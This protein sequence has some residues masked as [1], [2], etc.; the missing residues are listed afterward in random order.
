MTK[1]FWFA[2]FFVLVGPFLPPRSASA[3]AFGGTVV[4]WGTNSCF[5]TTLPAGFTNI[6]AIAAGNC[7]SIALRTDGTVVGWGD[8]SSPTLSP[9]GGL[10]GVRA[11]A[12][13]G[14]HMLAL[15]NDGTV[16]GWGLSDKGQANTTGLTGVK[17]I[18]AGQY[19]SVFLL[20]NGT[21]YAWGDNSFHQCD[22]YGQTGIAAIAAGANHTLALTAGGSVWA[23]G[24]NGYGQI[25]VPSVVD[26]GTVVALAGGANHSLALRANG[27]VRAWGQTYFGQCNVADLTGVTAIAAGQ[28][29]SLMLLNNRRVVVRGDNSVGQADV[30]STLS[31][32]VAISTSWD[33]SLALVV[34]PPS[35]ITQPQGMT[36]LVGSNLTFAVTVAG[37]PPLAYQWRKD[38]SL[39]AGATNASYSINNAQL[40][41]AGSYDAVVSNLTGTVISTAAVLVVNSPP[42]ITTHP[43]NQTVLVGMA[44]SLSVAAGGSPTLKYQWRKDGTNLS[45][46][47]STI[48]SLLGA[49]LTNAGIYTVVVTNLYGSVTSAPAT[50]VV[51]PRP[52]I[53]NSP[54]SQTVL[55]GASVAFSV[56]AAYADGYQWLKDNDPIPNANGPFYSLQAAQFDDAGTY[57]VMVTNQYGSALSSP[58][59]LT[60]RSPLP[61]STFVTQVG[62]AQ[63]FNGSAWVSLLPP[64]GLGNVLALSVGSNHSLALINDGTVLGWGDNSR[65]QAAPVG[66]SLVSNIA[67]GGLHSLA[68]TNGNRVAGWGA[69]DYGQ[70]TPPVAAAG[71]IIAIAA[72]SFHSLGLKRD[73]TVIGWGKGD[74]GLTNPPSSIANVAAIAAGSDFNLVLRSN[75]TVAAWGH[76]SE[77]YPRVPN[78]LTNAASAGIAAIAAGG[79]HCLALRSNGTVVAWGLN[80]AG[81][82]NVPAGLANVVAIAAGDRH[83]VALKSDGTVTAWGLNDDGQTD[84]PAN[85]GVVVG[86]AAGGNR[87]LLLVKKGIVV[88]P[89]QRRPGGGITI[90]FANSDGSA[91]DASLLAKLEVR[92]STNLTLSLSNW[93]SYTNGFVLTSGIV[94]WDDTN[95]AGLPRRFYR[96][97]EK[98]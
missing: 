8:D 92:A 46:S 51:N 89:P 69:N 28:Q 82:T 75:G 70:A 63:V 57:T 31:N 42:F 29:H 79:A 50:L 45:G 67:A 76:S 39:L 60:V 61:S 15:K 11:I 93:V 38:G 56:G 58:A 43:T 66:L 44:V 19:H 33:S 78:S 77:N 88:L 32:V 59:T 12:A 2:I 13:G 9:P 24:Q 36:V 47:T 27:T 22:G 62:Q 16:V 26:L 74:T 41:N 71:N 84:I 68:L 35:I 49:E 30:P 55:V 86:I 34:N 98:P 65:G 21:M 87:T 53:T 95:A 23:W 81:Q 72:G 80:D 73:G 48:F 5:N 97:G 96:T 54:Q 4:T 20:S 85:L 25:N 83:G 6:C 90:F 17:A 64:P 14:Y 1:Q 3:A 52:V 7:Y 94:R 18:A 10:T 40:T 37:S 91:V